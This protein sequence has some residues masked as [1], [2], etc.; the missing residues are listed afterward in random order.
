M[1]A[2]EAKLDEIVKYAQGAF[3][4]AKSDGVL[5]A[6]EVVQIAVGV[7]GKLQTL[8]QLTGS[9][10]K[11]VV[12]YCMKKGLDAAGGVG[13]LPGLKEVTAEMRK[14][15]EDQLLAAAGAAIDMAVAVA[16]GDIDL[17]K[18]GLK[19]C[20]PLCL[21]AAAVARNLLPKEAAIVKTALTWAEDQ[22]RAYAV[23][24]GLLGGDAEPA[25]APVPAAPAAAAPV[26][27]APAAAAPAAAAPA[28][29]LPAETPAPIQESAAPPAAPPAPAE[30]PVKVTPP[31]TESETAPNPEASPEEAPLQTHEVRF[32]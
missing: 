26:P 12:L 22:G 17:K 23:A 11:S 18:H 31:A 9:E 5:E 13:E 27:A 28:A 21:S 19:S 7:A 16:R 30:S 4:Q 2:T 10:K 3:I 14:A 6:G 8:G 29:P 24:Q 15:V 25:A 1:P 32:E 20:L